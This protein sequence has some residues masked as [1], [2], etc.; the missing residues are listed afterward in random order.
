MDLAC[1]SRRTTSAAFP[2][3]PYLLGSFTTIPSLRESQTRQIIG[4]T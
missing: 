1:D 2:A 3:S 4:S